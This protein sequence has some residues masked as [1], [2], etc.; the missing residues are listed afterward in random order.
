MACSSSWEEILSDFSE[1]EQTKVGFKRCLYRQDELEKSAIF[2][3]LQFISTLAI[4]RRQRWLILVS[5]H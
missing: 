2:S 1:E 4:P 3:K 5:E